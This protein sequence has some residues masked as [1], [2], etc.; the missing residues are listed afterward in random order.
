MRGLL[1]LPVQAD[2]SDTSEPAEP[3]LITSSLFDRDVAM[4]EVTRLDETQSG[5]LLER[6][7][8]FRILDRGGEYLQIVLPDYALDNRVATAAQ[9]V[10]ATDAA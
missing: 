10:T 9:N 4:I 7:G 2:S 3:Y 1:M 6:I 5:A 8:N